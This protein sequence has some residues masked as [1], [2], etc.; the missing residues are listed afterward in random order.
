[1]GQLA[2]ALA[3]L[4]RTLEMD[5]NLPLA[6]HERGMVY[7]L[8]GEH[9]SA[10]ADY[11][12][13][14]QLNPGS[15]LAYASRGIVR[16]LQ[17]DHAQAVSD[18]AR[19]L[20]L[21][22]KS[23]L[24]GWHQNTAE[25]IRRRT[26]QMLVEY[27]EGLWHQLQ[28]ARSARRRKAAPP[29]HNALPDLDGE[30]TA[31]LP[32]V[33]PSNS[34]EGEAAPK[35]RGQRNPAEDRGDPAS[36]AQKQTNGYVSAAATLPIAQA[37]EQAVLDDTAVELFLEDDTASPPPPDSSAE[38]AVVVAEPPP[39]P[40]VYEC[41]SCRAVGAP[42]ERLPD[43]RVRCGS[44]NAAFM[45][46]R[47]ASLNALT[48]AIARTPPV[49]AAAGKPKKP[50]KAD[51]D[52][53]GDGRLRFT[54][55]QKIILGTAAAL[56]G[57]VL[58]YYS[59][60]SFESLGAAAAGPSGKRIS[61]DDLLGEF[62]KNRKAAGR[63]YEEADLCVSGEVAEVFEDKQLV[64]FKGRD[65]KHFVDAGFRSAADMKGVQKNQK[66]CISGE[67]AGWQ[68][69]GNVLLMSCKVFPYE[70]PM[71]VPLGFNK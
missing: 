70:E 32:A 61:A 2:Q 16:Q 50:P 33:T 22:P 62:V 53:D 30:P 39:P 6:Y 7:M 23:I 20:E 45:P 31:E 66:V 60:P 27:I 35:R 12:R 64:R 34:P 10:V 54:L 5:P 57:I 59:F 21:N 71:Q 3:D 65:A 9:D 28:G 69:S 19:A 37:T 63:K 29:R 52:D 47:T 43:R 15:A 44:C 49:R 11:T 46:T 25:G 36:S 41:P 18:F 24:A 48:K 55:K 38:P 56:T 1:M 68:K 8:Q 13:M 51:D 58:V 17:G 67:C 42:S 26:T 40:T 4:T 14:L